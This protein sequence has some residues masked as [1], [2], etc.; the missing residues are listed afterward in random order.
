MDIQKRKCFSRSI[1]SFFH[2]FF[3]KAPPPT[4]KSH[5]ITDGIFLLLLE[6][7]YDFIEEGAL[8]FILGAVFPHFIGK[9]KECVLLVFVQPLRHRHMDFHIE[10]PL[11]EDCR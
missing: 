2:A 9:V 8:S 5:R 6:L 11:R 3:P 1:S 4:Q 7:V 10:V